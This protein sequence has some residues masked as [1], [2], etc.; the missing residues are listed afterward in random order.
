MGTAQP[1]LEVYSISF[2]KGPFKD[3]QQAREAGHANSGIYMIKPKNSNEPMQLWCENSLD[4]GGWAVIQKRTD[5]SV[6]FFRNWDSYKVNSRMQKISGQRKITEKSDHPSEANT[7]QWECPISLHAQL[8][9][10]EPTWLRQP[11]LVMHNTTGRHVI[12]DSGWEVIYYK[13]Q[14]NTWFLLTHWE[15]QWVFVKLHLP[16]LWIRKLSQ[17]NYSF[18]WFILTLRDVLDQGLNL[19]IVPIMNQRKSFLP[20]NLG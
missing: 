4:P 17:W 15:L 19:K 1:I 14:L 11:G 8:T 2:P 16:P 10:Y 18:K 5:G 20:I 12:L 6:N 3:C 9:L 13:V 7:F